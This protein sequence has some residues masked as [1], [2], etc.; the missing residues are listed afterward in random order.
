MKVK[1]SGVFEPPFSQ[2]RE[3]AAPR[4]ELSEQ[5]LLII[6]GRGRSDDP[7]SGHRCTAGPAEAENGPGR[8]HQEILVPVYAD[9]SGVHLYGGL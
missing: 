6:D 4:L 1:R 3:A 9:P 7:A 8:V 2:L 5:L